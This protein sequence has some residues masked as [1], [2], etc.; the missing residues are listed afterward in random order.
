M[1]KKIIIIIL[2][3]I[4]VLVLGF[5]AFLIIRDYNERNAGKNN[6]NENNENNQNGTQNEVV[7]NETD[8]SQ[9]ITTNSNSTIRIINYYDEEMFKGKNTILFMWASWCP[10]CAT[11]LDALNELLAKYKNDPDFNIVFIAHEFKDSGIDDLVELLEGGTVNYDTEI[12]VDF[13]RVIRH[14]IDP[15]A[16]T[17]PKTYF[18]D[19]DSNLLYKIDDAVTVEQIDSLIGEYYK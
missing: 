5:G 16:S 13:G 9:V 3:I 11:E 19:K 10:H 4:L 14:A 2:C 17:V 15:E 18:L 6:N 8:N 7:F 1:N 12:L